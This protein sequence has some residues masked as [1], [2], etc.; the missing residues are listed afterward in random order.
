M[1]TTYLNTRPDPAVYAFLRMDFDAL[2]S[3]YGGVVG[4]TFRT[5]PS[6]PQRYIERLA[7]QPPC[8]PDLA[9]VAV[10]PLRIAQQ[11]TRY[12]DSDLHVREFRKNTSR[13]IA[14]KEMFDRQHPMYWPP[15]APRYASTLIQ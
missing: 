10:E 1:V 5:F 14:A 12:A 9:N 7:N 8:E 3:R 2:V 6:F 13:R 4:A 11:P 15:D